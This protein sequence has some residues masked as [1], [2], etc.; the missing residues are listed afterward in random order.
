MKTKQLLF[1]IAGLLM[2]GLTAN[3]QRDR[4]SN[5]DYELDQEYNLDAQGTVHLSSSDAQVN[6]KGTDRNNVHLVVNRYEDV[7]GVSSSRRSFEIDVEE[8]NGDLYI[9]ERERRG[10]NIRMGYYSV[11]Y[12][13]DIEMPMT[14]SLR[15]KGDDD[16]YVIRSVNGKI[17]IAVDDGDIELINCE[18]DDFDIELEDGDL[19]MD[20]GKGNFYGRIDDGDIDIRNGNFESVEIRAEDGNVSIETSLSNKG[21]YELSADDARIDF[22]VLSGGGKFNVLKDDG[23]VSADSTFDTIRETD[24]RSQLELKGG[25]AEVDIRVNDGRVRLSSEY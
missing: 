16:D 12:D 14:G 18:G 7:R 3:A 9:T 24:S 20:G 25:D 5:T 13:I 11:D 17:S 23:R 21:T 4:N 15:I 6:I 19:K 2:I 10:V 22:V 1:S 8:R